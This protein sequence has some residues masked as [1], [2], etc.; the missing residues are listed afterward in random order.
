V[1]GLDVMAIGP[2]DDKLVAEAKRRKLDLCAWTIDDPQLA[3]RLVELGIPGVTTNR[4]G[5]L[6]QEL[7]RLMQ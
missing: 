1:D 2:I 4:P 7:Q 5:W 6:R 3:K